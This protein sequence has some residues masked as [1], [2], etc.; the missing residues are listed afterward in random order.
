MYVS[1]TSVMVLTLKYMQ[2]YSGFAMQTVASSRCRLTWSTPIFSFPFSNVT[3][4]ANGCR[5]TILWVPFA[6]L[7][8]WLKQPWLWLL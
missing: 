6:E 8:L 3:G 2:P 1:S 7:R 4:H 5:S